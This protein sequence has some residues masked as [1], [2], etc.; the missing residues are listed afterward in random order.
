MSDTTMGN[1][2][3]ARCPNGAKFYVLGLRLCFTHNE[4]MKEHHGA[5]IRR[6]MNDLGAVTDDECPP[7][8]NGHSKGVR[9]GRGS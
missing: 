1:C 5:M 6:L 4:V 7:V 9:D 2:E 3:F 8:A